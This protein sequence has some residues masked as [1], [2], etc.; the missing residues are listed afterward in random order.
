MRV[1]CA[2]APEVGKGN[3]LPEAEAIALEDQEKV[4][5]LRRPYQMLAAKPASKRAYQLVCPSMPLSLA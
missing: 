4:K 5:S 1:A 3:L 2:I